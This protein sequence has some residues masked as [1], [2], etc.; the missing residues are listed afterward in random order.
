MRCRGWKYVEVDWK[1]T[2]KWQG[3]GGFGISDVYLL[4]CLCLCLCFLLLLL[5]FFFFFFLLLLVVGCCSCSWTRLSWLYPDLMMRSMFDLGYD[6][7]SHVG[8]DLVCRGDVPWLNQ[9]R[10]TWF[11]SWGV[12]IPLDSA[13]SCSEQTFSRFHKTRRIFSPN[14]YC[15]GFLQPS[16][17]EGPFCSLRKSTVSPP[18]VTQNCCWSR[19]SIYSSLRF[20]SSSLLAVVVVVAAVSVLSQ[21][22]MIFFHS[23]GSLEVRKFIF[24][25][26]KCQQD[27]KVGIVYLDTIVWIWPPHSNSGIFAGL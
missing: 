13:E 26:K 18:K 21:L 15:W 19:E 16:F 27:L 24:S 20:L 1:V 2:L 23:S 6:S 4:I 17:C 3:C 22:W 11:V 9:S 5:F 10:T 14:V 7:T 12:M 8:T 25:D